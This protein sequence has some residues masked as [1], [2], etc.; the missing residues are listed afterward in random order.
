M[1]RLLGNAAEFSMYAL[2]RKKVLKR[3]RL[4]PRY[5]VKVT[6]LIYERIIDKTMNVT[7]DKLVLRKIDK[8]HN[9]IPNPSP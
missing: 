1:E 8:I 5:C 4:R 3:R 6:R 7:L 9:K 2:L